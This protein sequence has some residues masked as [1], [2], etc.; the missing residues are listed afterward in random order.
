MRNWSVLTPSAG[1]RFWRSRCT[2]PA[3]V[4]RL[5]G[6]QQDVEGVEQDRA[7]PEGFGHLHQKRWKRTVGMDGAAIHGL[8]EGPRHRAR[9]LLALRRR[10]VRTRSSERMFV[11]HGRW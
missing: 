6:S 10:G 7:D 4:L 1:N 3:F 9:R 8:L 2:W 11:D 5:P